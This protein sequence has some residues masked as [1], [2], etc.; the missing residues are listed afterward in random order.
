[1]DYPGHNTNPGQLPP[2][3]PVSSSAE[4][5][6]Q[7]KQGIF[8]KTNNFSIFIKAKY[9]KNNHTEHPKTKVLNSFEFLFN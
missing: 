9:S 7:L 1:V 4:F 3:Y 5:S 6:S 2:L 8:L